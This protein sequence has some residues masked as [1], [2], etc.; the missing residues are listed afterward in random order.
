MNTRNTATQI[1]VRTVTNESLDSNSRSVFARGS[2][3]AGAKRALQRGFPVRLILS[4]VFLAGSLCG[5]NATVSGRVVDSQSEAV[6]QAEV[7]MLTA[8]CTHD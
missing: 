5:Q 3:R 4:A 2:R 8:T 1:E 6:P 7:V